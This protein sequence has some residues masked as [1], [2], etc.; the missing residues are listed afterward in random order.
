[1]RL[2]SFGAKRRPSTS[3]AF[4]RQPSKTAVQLSLHDRFDF[5]KRSRERST[6]CGDV[7]PFRR[8]LRQTLA[9]RTRSVREPRALLEL[10]PQSC[11]TESGSQRRPQHHHN[12]CHRWLAQHRRAV[13]RECQIVARQ[14]CQRC[15]SVRSHHRSTLGPTCQCHQFHRSKFAIQAL[16]QDYHQSSSGQSRC[17]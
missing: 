6:S 8:A 10:S 3:T 4:F 12:R 15:R 2:T 17:P 11:P 9:R 14:K 13:E 16:C 1:M 5:S 7:A